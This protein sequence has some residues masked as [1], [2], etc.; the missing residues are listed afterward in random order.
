MD[1]I[2]VTD[3]RQDIDRLIAAEIGLSVAASVRAAADDIRARLGGHA[4]AILFYGS[5]LRRG[6]D[7]AED[8]D[9]VLDFYVLVE[10]YADLYDNRLL[11]LANLLLP[12]NVFYAEVPWQGRS[13]RVKY[14]IV[15]EASFRR[16]CTSRSLHSLLWGRFAQP[17][18]LVYAQD[19]PARRNVTDALGDAVVTLLAAA[20]PLVPAD[21]SALE[22]WTRALEESYRT[23]L[24]TERAGRAGDIVAADGARYA[25]LTPLA[26]TL[27]RPVSP[28]RARALWALRRAIGKPMSVARLAKG[29]FTFTGGQSYILWKLHRHSGVTLAPTPWQQRHPL[30]SAPVLAWRLYRRGAF[31]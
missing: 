14:A 30:L 12:P 7:P 27:A 11:A 25:A 2:S 28:A 15:S 16:G 24:R 22:P 17:V 1:E 20:L 21:G 13:L 8:D 29:V 3:A 4:R 5:C 23:E 9:S 31:R 18:R 26:M 19:E 6:G 10:G